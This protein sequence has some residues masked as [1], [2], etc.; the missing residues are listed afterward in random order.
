MPTALDRPRIS[1]GPAQQQVRTNSLIPCRP[2]FAEGIFQG[3]D[4][5]GDGGRVVSR[6]LFSPASCFFWPPEAKPP[7]LRHAEKDPGLSHQGLS[8]YVTPPSTFP[9]RNSTSLVTLSFSNFIRSRV[10]RR[11]TR[12][13]DSS[14]KPC[15]SST[16]T[17][18]LSI[19][20]RLFTASSFSKR[21]EF[22][23]NSQQKRY[24]KPIPPTLAPNCGNSRWLVGIWGGGGG[25]V[26]HSTATPVYVCSLIRIIFLTCC[27]PNFFL[28][29]FV[30]IVVDFFP[31]KSGHQRS[32]PNG[33]FILFHS[34]RWVG[35]TTH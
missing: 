35:A 5:V 15:G 13:P 23:G 27:I 32:H 11:P 31:L 25:G 16:L 30:G 20:S 34:R 19:V 17:R 4:G 33:G 12:L 6:Q 29:E 1:R 21:I 9:D 14:S 24:Q 3:I 2:P 26:N 7:L 22:W 10:S 28:G 18:K 8:V